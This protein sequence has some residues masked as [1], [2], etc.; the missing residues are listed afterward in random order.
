MIICQET[1]DGVSIVFLRGVLDFQTAREFTLLFE[2]VQ[3]SDCRNIVLD[4]ADVEFIDSQSL[5]L[6]ITQALHF[7]KLG[8]DVRL[9]R[10]PPRLMRVFELVRLGDVL[11]FFDDHELA[12]Q[13]F[14][15]GSRE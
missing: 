14:A 6:I 13:S 1:R 15:R 5:S 11:E 12:I 8:G 10:V 4:L 2:N 3:K 9:C 7:R